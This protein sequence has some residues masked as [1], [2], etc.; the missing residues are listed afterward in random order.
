MEINEDLNKRNESRGW[1][2]LFALLAMSLRGRLV[3]RYL[4]PCYKIWSPQSRAGEV[5]LEHVRA[6]PL[7]PF[8]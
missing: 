7:R 3:Q 1:E 6:L 5:L 4:R 2:D 8:S